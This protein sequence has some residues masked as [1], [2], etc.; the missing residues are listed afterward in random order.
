M[1]TRLERG[2]ELHV[3]VF[4]GKSTCRR[5][6]VLIKYRDRAHKQVDILCTIPFSTTTADIPKNSLLLAQGCQRIRR[7]PMRD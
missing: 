3:V 4:R 7:I 1:A 6:E 2:R 5:G